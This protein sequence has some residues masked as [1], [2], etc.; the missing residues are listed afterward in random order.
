[1]LLPHGQMVTLHWPAASEPVDSKYVQ[2]SED[3]DPQVAVTENTKSTSSHRGTFESELFSQNFKYK[4]WYYCIV[5][6][7][8]AWR[9]RCPKCTYMCST[10]HSQRHK[11]PNWS[12]L[13]GNTRRLCSMFHFWSQFQCMD[14]F[15]IWY[16]KIDEWFL[17][18]K[19]RFCTY[20]TTVNKFTT[21]KEEEV[22]N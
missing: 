3:V 6:K 18:L 9:V 13:V 4:C 15:E 11:I 14:R 22:I 21:N 19:S 17:L 7:Y 10:L 20:L 1:M 8:L 5:E 16:Q 2:F 12:L